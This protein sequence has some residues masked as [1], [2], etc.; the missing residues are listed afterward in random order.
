MSTP[1]ADDPG[2]SFGVLIEMARSH[3]SWDFLDE[4]FASLGATAQQR[5]FGHDGNAHVT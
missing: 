4:P 3:L 5:R 2:T 1:P